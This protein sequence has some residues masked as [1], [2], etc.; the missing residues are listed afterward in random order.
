[1]NEEI[2]K[3]LSTQ[4]LLQYAI[5]LIDSHI[6]LEKTPYSEDAIKQSKELLT[7]ISKE[8]TARNTPLL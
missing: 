5:S 3:A 2:I 8:I 4:Q 1:M 7:M 6:S